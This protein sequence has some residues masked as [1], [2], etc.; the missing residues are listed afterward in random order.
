MLTSVNLNL[1]IKYVYT[2]C[3]ATIA[4][5]ITFVCLGLNG[6]SKLKGYDG[7]SGCTAPPPWRVPPNYR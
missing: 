1:N 3:P 6:T 7:M 4:V 5:L 2:L